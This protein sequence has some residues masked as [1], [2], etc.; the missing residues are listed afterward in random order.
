MADEKTNQDRSSG[1]SPSPAPGSS[2]DSPSPEQW[3]EPLLARVAQT[4]EVGTEAQGSI[5]ASQQAIRDMV[6]TAFGQIAIERTAAAARETAAARREL[7][8]EQRIADLQAAIGGFVVDVQNVFQ[9]LQVLHGPAVDSR[10]AQQGV[11]QAMVVF[12]E[13][14]REATD[15]IKLQRAEDDDRIHASPK[16]LRDLLVRLA[17][18]TWPHSVRLG[19]LAALHLVKLVV[20]TAAFAALMEIIRGYLHHGAN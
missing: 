3:L 15:S 19:K 2:S 4:I 10:K 6:Q 13:R 20:G 14:I 18:F 8:Y 16:T 5:A 9:A 1:Q 12:N 17:D 7:R 11:E